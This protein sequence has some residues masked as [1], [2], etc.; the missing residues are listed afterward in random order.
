MVCAW[1]CDG[2][3]LE[4]HELTVGKLPVLGLTVMSKSGVGEGLFI[5]INN[6]SKEIRAAA[7][8]RDVNL[9]K[10]IRDLNPDIESELDKH[11]AVQRHEIGDTSVV[12]TATK[13][14]VRL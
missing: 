7:N 1:E 3:C 4:F 9:L 11:F 12:V 8:Q 2:I 5:A 13:P 10:I 6:G 14:V